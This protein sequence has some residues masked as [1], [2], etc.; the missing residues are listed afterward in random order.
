MRR[1]IPLKYFP[2]KKLPGRGDI[3]ARASLSDIVSGVNYCRE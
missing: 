2:R 3:A 1:D